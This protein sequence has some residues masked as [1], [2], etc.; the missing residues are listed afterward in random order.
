MDITFTNMVDEAYSKLYKNQ[1]NNI[2]TSEINLPE[3]DIII[4]PTRL[5]WK[6][7]TDFLIKINRPPQHFIHFLQYE[8]PSVEIHWVSATVFDNG[9]II[10]G[11][12]QKKKNIIDIMNKYINNFVV[13]MS[14]QSIDTTLTKYILHKYTFNCLKCNYS[15]CM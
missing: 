12:R 14:C 8:L 6:N 15:K 9:I 10:H 3:Y 2:S 1:E 13:C 5:H 11:K 7:V 4:E